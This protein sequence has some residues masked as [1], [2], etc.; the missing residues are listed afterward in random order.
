MNDII[1]ISSMIKSEGAALR[2]ESRYQFVFDQKQDTYK[3][4]RK[5]KLVGIITT[6]RSGDYTN[7]FA[8]YHNLRAYATTAFW[9]WRNIKIAREIASKS[10]VDQMLDEMREAKG[11]P[12]TIK[13]VVIALSV[14]D[15]EVTERVENGMLITSIRAADRKVPMEVA[16]VAL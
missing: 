10:V 13:E 5:G 12:L 15:P 6:N 9:R 3:V 14:P 8:G 11:E 16:E 1:P 2:E 4:Y 7:M